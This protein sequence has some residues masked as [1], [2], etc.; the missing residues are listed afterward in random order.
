MHIEGTQFAQ[1]QSLPKGPSHRPGGR[2]RAAGVEQQ[3]VNLG[4]L[5]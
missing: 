4:S 1:G 5:G 3:R 2:L